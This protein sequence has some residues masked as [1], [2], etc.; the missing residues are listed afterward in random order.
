MPSVTACCPFLADDSHVKLAKE[1]EE[2]A[3]MS[4]LRHGAPPLRCKLSSLSKAEG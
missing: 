1:T 2:R 4:W 3:S